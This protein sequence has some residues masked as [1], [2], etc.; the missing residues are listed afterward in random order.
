MTKAR[1]EKQA[2]MKPTLQ[3]LGDVA[4]L[5]ASGTKQGQENNGNTLG[6]MA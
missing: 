6:T 5:T 2:Y 4:T 1:N 3:R